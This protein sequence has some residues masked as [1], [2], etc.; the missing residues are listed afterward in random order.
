[1]I[2]LFFFSGE[3][4]RQGAT[5]SAEDVTSGSFLQQLHSHQTLIQLQ[6]RT[7]FFV[8]ITAFFQFLCA[9]ILLSRKAWVS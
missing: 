9:S 1:M 6:R 3:F 7:V 2:G 8:T 5:G 4:A